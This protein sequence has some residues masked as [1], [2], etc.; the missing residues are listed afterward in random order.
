[1]TPAKAPRIEI[2]GSRLSGRGLVILGIAVWVIL[3]STYPRQLHGAGMLLTLLLVSIDVVLGVVTGW[4]AFRRTEELDERQAALRDHAYRLAFRL[5]GV[6]VLLMVALVY[7]GFFAPNPEENP[8]Q[9]Y[10]PNGLAARQLIAFLELLVVVPTAVIAWIDPID[11]EEVA[12]RS[13]RWRTWMPALLIPVIA[14]SWLLAVAVLP[15][16]SATLTQLP[17]SGFSLSGATCGHFIAKKDVGSVFG[18]SIRLQAEVCWD[19]RNAFVF[20]DPSLHTPM[21]IVPTPV[22]ADQLAAPLTMPSLPNLTNCRPRN[23]DTDFVA[24]AESCNEQ[25]EANGTMRLIVHGRVSPLPGGL[26]A[27]DVEI[28]LVVA[29]D[30]RVVSFD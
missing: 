2:A 12:E 20:G 19:G 6:G 29:P 16:Q 27:R 14:A 1:M 9:P 7:A 5:V 18:G 26:L 3:A 10:L 30:G 22:A 15:I 28:R 17:D 25:I 11:P 21:G 24:V 4:L 8:S 13:K 23:A